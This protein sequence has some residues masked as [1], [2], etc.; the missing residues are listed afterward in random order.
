ML[1]DQVGLYFGW[2][3][4]LSLRCRHGTRELIAT[5]DFIPDNICNN[6]FPNTTFLKAENFPL[7]SYRSR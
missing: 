3:L 5:D 2:M 6:C 4:V 1:Q 7:L